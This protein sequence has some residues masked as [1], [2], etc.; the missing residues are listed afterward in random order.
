MQA[1]SFTIKV[2]GHVT[3][4]FSIQSNSNNLDDQGSRGAGICIDKGVEVKTTAKK[5]N[6]KVTVCSDEKN[7]SAR[8]Y[9]L[10]IEQTSKQF[11]AVNEYNWEFEIKS[12]LPFGQGFGC[13]A[14]GAL[15]A[16]ICILRIIDETDSLFQNALTIAHRVERIM[17]GGLGDVTALGV[18]GVELRLEPGLPFSPNKGLILGWSAEFPMLLCW[19]ND[20]ER[21]TSEY[22]DNENWKM[23]ISSA[24]EQCISKLNKKEWNEDR[25][26]DLLEQSK[27]FSEK[28]GMLFDSN[29]NNIIT[30]LEDILNEL[31]ISSFWD[32]RLCMLGTSAILLP[33]HLEE[34]N[35]KDLEK[36]LKKLKGLKLTG[37]IAHLNSNPLLI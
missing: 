5:G 9:N 34:Y 37:C 23:K 27:L 24:G 32:V 10:V 19:V 21:H 4:L 28:S 1:N 31:N 11:E 15:S 13:S 16:V 30:I 6:G 29:R 8:L 36:V 14:S 25:W 3:L 26:G 35:K 18:G 33:R 22:I 20:E 17:S 12:D 2:G 7:L